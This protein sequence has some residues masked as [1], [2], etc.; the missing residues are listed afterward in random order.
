MAFRRPQDVSLPRIL[1]VLFAGVLMGA[2]DIAI[3][4]P[5]LPAIQ[6]AFGVDGR[7]LSRVFNIYILFHL[8][9]APLMAKLSDRYGRRDVYAVSVGLFAAGSL[10]VAFS[11][12]FTVLLLGRAIQGL[13]AGGIFPV[14]SAVIGD[15][16]PE[17]RRGGAL[18]LIGAVFGLAFILGP[19]LG[20]ILLR[21]GWQWLFLVNLPVAV[22]VLWQALQVLPT[23]RAA[24]PKRFDAP[25]AVLLTV[26]LAGLAWGVSE[27]DA[28][29][30]RASIVSPQILPFLLLAA[31]A[32]PAF[33]IVERHAPDPVLHPS[34]LGSRELRLVA[35]IALATGFAEAGMVF[36]PSLAVAGLGVADATA[37]FMLIPLVATLLVGSPTA[38]YL[39][40][41]VGSKAVIQGG[42]LLTVAG[43]L[44]FGLPALTRVTFYAGGALVGFGLSALLGAPLRY[45]VLRE[46]RDEWRGAGQGLLTLCLSVGRLSGAALVGGVA[47]SRGEPA[48]GYQEALL[49]VAGLISLAV[50]LSVF[51][52]SGRSKP[53]RGA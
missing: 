40:D 52:R 15:T 32:A 26:M 14:A 20:G 47:A 43:L 49:L 27:L 17:N 33:W 24:A 41:R 21:W 30:L 11:P 46:A 19:L 53:V 28:T 39:L 9:A 50:I 35:V 38:G 10:I 37:S 31:L 22:I 12:D 4:G 44:V 42:L 45:V 25:G 51:L 23:T 1:A 7:G 48:A 8:V 16:F 34:L 18:G 13:G 29:Q 36:L 3:V 5:A 2:L 6:A